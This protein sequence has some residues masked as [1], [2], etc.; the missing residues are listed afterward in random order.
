MTRSSTLA[1]L[2][3]TAAS[4]AHGAAV[5][6]P[7]SK[8]AELFRRWNSH[9]CTCALANV[10]IPD[11]VTFQLPLENYRQDVCYSL[12]IP[13]TNT[14]AGQFCWNF[15][16]NSDALT[17][18]IKP[19]TGY[20]LQGADVS[21][22]LTAA[23]FTSKSYSTNDGGCG[24]NS[25]TGEV[26]CIIPWTDISGKTELRDVLSA[27]CPN[28][29][30][31]G[32]ILYLGIDA[33][34]SENGE[35]YVAVPRPCDATNPAYTT[36]DT[37]VPYF[38]LA[39]RCTACPT[40]QEVTKYCSFGTAFGYKDPT[41]SKT[42][43]SL[44]ATGCN[45]WGWYEQVPFASLAGL[46]GRLLVGAGLNDLSKATDVGSWTAV[47]AGGKVS[48]TYQASTGY[49][50]ADVHVD[51]RCSLPTSCAPGRYTY[52]NT[53]AAATTTSGFTTSPIVIPCASGNVNL[54][55]HAAVNRVVSVPAAEADGYTCPAM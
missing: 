22:G 37:S 28:G 46:T 12:I 11:S 13:S 52:G 15:N 42:L 49:S 9:L 19:S 23:T 5:S 10:A 25:A 27:M 40:C 48:V 51:V 43:D 24:L 45:R 33:N 34:L 35:S 30:R 20:Q 2:A 21:F 14:P 1:L 50:L 6:L 31:E 3:S 39:Y 38:E 54:I 41:L 4:L 8:P 32:L 47:V 17:L 36:C 55:V 7:L 18:D 53:F 16:A 29:D 44:S 26:N